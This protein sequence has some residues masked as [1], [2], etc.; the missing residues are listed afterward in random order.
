MIT[1]PVL[2]WDNEQVLN[3]I[4][5]VCPAQ[6]TKAE[7]TTFINT[8]RSMNLNPF[9]KEIYCLKNGTAAMQIIVARDGYRKVAQREAEYDYHQTDAVYSND[10]FRVYHGEV[11]HEYDLTDRGCIIGA[12]CTVKRRSSS[13]SMYAY[14]E[15]K[16]YDL[17][18]SLWTT[19]P[20]T[21]IKK[22]A[23]AHALRMAFQDV[24]IGTYDKDELPEDMTEESA[25]KP[26]KAPDAMITEE[27]VERIDSLMQLADMS[28][29]RIL[30]GIEKIYKKKELHELTEADAKDFI[31]RLE[32]RVKNDI[33]K[34]EDTSVEDKAAYEEDKQNKVSEAVRDIGNQAT[35]NTNQFT[36]I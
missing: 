21:M 24:F 16:E 36:E 32:L 28:F 27:Q 35:D 34:A 13:K 15:L 14:V 1:K 8:C 17:K 10:K 9:T 6:L 26:S 7:F 20:A 5:A 4:R 30:L 23:E 2:D 22:V 18:R 31:R 3:D 29:E 33:N 11:E 25:V 19:K 12:Y